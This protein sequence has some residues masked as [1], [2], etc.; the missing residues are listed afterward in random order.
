MHAAA[1]ALVAAR[2][3]HP[4]GVLVDIRLGDEDGMALAEQLT[5]LPWRPRVVLTSA[6]A[7]AATADEVRRCGTGA[8]LSKDE[9]PN[10]PLKRLLGGSPEPGPDHRW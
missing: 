8:F 6:H 10:A 1:T 2:D 9:L 7:D 5:A 4:H 3:L